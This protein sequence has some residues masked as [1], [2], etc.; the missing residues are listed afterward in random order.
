[1]SR[2]PQIHFLLCEVVIIFMYINFVP[3]FRF[4]VLLFTVKNSTLL[5]YT[6]LFLPFP[7]VLYIFFSP[8][9]FKKS[10]QPPEVVFFPNFILVLFLFCLF[11][12]S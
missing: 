10:C 4:L 3:F 12:F 1:M 8:Y 2:I 6:A 11:E 5:I 7:V 9:F